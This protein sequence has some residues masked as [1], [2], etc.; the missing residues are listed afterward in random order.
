MVIHSR[1]EKHRFFF[2]ASADAPLVIAISSCLTGQ[3]V[4]YDGD[5][6]PLA[7]P[8][9]WHAANIHLLPICPEVAAG[10]GVPRPPVQLIATDDGGVCARGRDDPTLDVTDALRAQA[11]RTLAELAATPQ[12]CGY[13]WKSRSPSCGLGSTPLF[14]RDGKHEIRQGSG[15]QAQHVAAHLPWLI[16][17][18]ETALQSDA[19]WRRFELLCRLVRDGRDAM[20]AN[21]PLANWHRH[22][23]PL[24]DLFASAATA[25]LERLSQGSGWTAYLSAFRHGCEKTKAEQ[26]LGLFL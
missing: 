9:A 8:D 11:R 14:D 21:V 5:S 18:E 2:A 19:D 7:L 1:F 6:K 22:Y 10:L 12:L 13:V 4:R 17:C 23:R 24:R 15:L 20:H 25:E 26:L 16:H 3:R